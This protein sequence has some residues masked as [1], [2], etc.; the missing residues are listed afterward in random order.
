M[1]AIKK[2]TDELKQFKSLLEQ[3]F[4]L[5]HPSREDTN[6]LVISEAGY[7]GCPVISVKNFAIP[8]L[9]KNG[10][11]G[12]LLD[13]PAD[14]EAIV[15]AVRSVIEDPDK[16]KGMRRRARKYALQTSNWNTV[17]NR[18]AQHIKEVLQ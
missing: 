5:V 18:I 7:F 17:G 14:P 13:Y 12:I 16:Y 15:S 4:L 2:N 9:V 8:E 11:N 6:P 3:A 10:E 1:T